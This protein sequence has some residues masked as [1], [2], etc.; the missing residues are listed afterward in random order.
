MEGDD[1]AGGVGGGV[2]GGGGGILGWVFGVG[3]V[4]GWGLAVKGGLDE[5]IWGDGMAAR[6]TSEV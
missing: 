5:W 6:R 1:S 3:G 4:V 2:G